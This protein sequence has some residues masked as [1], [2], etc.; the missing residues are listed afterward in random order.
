M[1]V[2]CC[3][4]RHVLVRGSRRVDHVSGGARRWDRLAVLAQGFDVQCDG[5]PHETPNF[6]Q[7]VTARDAARKIGNICGIAAI[8][9]SLDH[10]HVIH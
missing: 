2:Q 6:I 9:R 3:A 4:M 7:R 5:I 10:Y 8:R 1:S